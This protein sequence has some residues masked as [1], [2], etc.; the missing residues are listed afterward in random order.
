MCRSLT[1]QWVRD[2]TNT[3]QPQEEAKNANTEETKQK[4]PAKKKKAKGG[5]AAMDIED[6]G[7]CSFYDNFEARSDQYNFPKD[8]FTLD[9]L[10]RLGK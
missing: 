1:A 2:E 8:I 7:R 6:M 5:K 3:Q 10:K 4:P 9:D